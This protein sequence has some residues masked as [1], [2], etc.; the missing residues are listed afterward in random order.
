[1]TMSSHGNSTLT[2]HPCVTESLKAVKVLGVEIDFQVKVDEHVP[3]GRSEDGRQ[4]NIL[5]GP[6]K[7]LDL[8]GKLENN[9]YW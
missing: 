3:V 6:S 9:A 2:I 4:I 1:M 5:M 8:N 7:T